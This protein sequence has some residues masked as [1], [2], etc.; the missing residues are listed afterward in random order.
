LVDRADIGNEWIG[1]LVRL[2]LVFR[3]LVLLVTLYS[4]HP[5]QRWWGWR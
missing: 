1:R 4:L 2:L 3:T 5:A